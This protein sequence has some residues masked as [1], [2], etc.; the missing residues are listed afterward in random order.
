MQ[1]SIGWLLSRFQARA[2]EIKC[3]KLTFSAGISIEVKKNIDTAD[4]SLKHLNRTCSNISNSLKTLIL[5]IFFRR[6][7]RQVTAAK[8]T[9]RTSIP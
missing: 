1:Q 3:Q 9:P 7:E 5:V 8:Q 2:C 6:L 4:F